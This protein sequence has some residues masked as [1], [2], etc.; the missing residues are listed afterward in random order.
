VFLTDNEALNISH[1]ISQ[2]KRRQRAFPD[3]TSTPLNKR[4]KVSDDVKDDKEAQDIVVQ[5]NPFRD[6]KIGELDVDNLLDGLSE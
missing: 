3:S 2:T 1:T 4:V 6:V 5:N